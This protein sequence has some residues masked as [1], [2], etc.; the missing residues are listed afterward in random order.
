MFSMTKKTPTGLW[1]RWHGACAVKPE[2]YRD[3]SFSITAPANQSVGDIAS[4]EGEGISLHAGIKKPDFEAMVDDRPGIADELI[5]P[6]R[7]H[8]ALPF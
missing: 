8:D 1:P 7:R 5:K 4:A 2:E 6:L 3:S